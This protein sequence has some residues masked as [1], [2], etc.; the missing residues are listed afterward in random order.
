MNADALRLRWDRAW[1]E[2]PGMDRRSLLADVTILVGVAAP[3]SGIG[4]L[5]GSVRALLLGAFVLVGPGSA[6]LAWTTLPRT[7]VWI[8]MPCLGLAAICGLTTAALQAGWWSPLSL[9]VLLDAACLISAVLAR[10]SVPA[11]TAVHSS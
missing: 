10:R 4:V 11:P 9:L 2:P 1:S 7:V 8:V 6:V 5:P 3:A